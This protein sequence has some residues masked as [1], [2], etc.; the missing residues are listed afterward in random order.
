MF[1]PK[2]QCE[3]CQKDSPSVPPTKV[4]SQMSPEER[5]RVFLYAATGNRDYLIQ[6]SF[7]MPKEEL[8]ITYD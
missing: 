8:R 1:K 2:C 7:Y 5:M 6:E 3:K 4:L